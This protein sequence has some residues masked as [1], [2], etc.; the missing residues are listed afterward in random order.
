MKENQDREDVK[1]VYEPTY[2]DTCSEEEIIETNVFQYTYR[3]C[4]A[5]GMSEDDSYAEAYAASM[6]YL[7]ETLGGVSE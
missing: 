1:S 7:D 6:Q 2:T 3:N 5:R 4:L